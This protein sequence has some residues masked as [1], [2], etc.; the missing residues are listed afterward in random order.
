MA[1]LSFSNEKGQLS[2]RPIW[3]IQVSSSFRLEPLTRVKNGR[4]WVLRRSTPKMGV[5]I[6]LSQFIYLVLHSVL[7]L[8]IKFPAILPQGPQTKGRRQEGS[9]R[10][11]CHSK[12]RK[13][14]VFCTGMLKHRIFFIRNWNLVKIDRHEVCVNPMGCVWTRFRLQITS[15]ELGRQRS[16]AVVLES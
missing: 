4:S 6:K 15:L 12:S 13:L 7:H 2:S 3:L 10:K 8:Y 5:W 14:A 1:S 11:V 16:D 9:R